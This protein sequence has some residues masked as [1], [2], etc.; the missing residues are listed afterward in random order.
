MTYLSIVVF[1][2]TP[3]PKIAPMHMYAGTNYEVDHLESIKLA[4]NVYRERER[5]K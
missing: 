5:K 4:K 2:I 3:S 1:R